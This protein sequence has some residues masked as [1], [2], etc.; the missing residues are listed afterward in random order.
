ML[1][2]TKETLMLTYIN[3]LKKIN[4][5]VII[6]TSWPTTIKYTVQWFCFLTILEHTA[7]IMD[8]N[9]G[10]ISSLLK[11]FAMFELRLNHGEEKFDVISFRCI[12]CKM[13]TGLYLKNKTFDEMITKSVLNAILHHVGMSR[14]ISSNK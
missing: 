10:L 12:N 9:N 7:K 5:I 3:L 14:I 6:V 4:S 13:E 8:T 2:N 1:H 11:V